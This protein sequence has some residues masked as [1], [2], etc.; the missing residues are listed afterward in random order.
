V[1]FR[2]ILAGVL[3]LFVI[4]CAATAAIAQGP[5]AP[6]PSVK[7]IA[8][9]WEGTVQVGRNAP[10]PVSIEIREDGSYTGQS[11]RGPIVGNMWMESGVVRSKSNN[12]PARWTLTVKDGKRTLH[13][14]AENG[15]GGGEFTEVK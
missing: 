8:G 13:S 5:A 14:M 4:S 11:P 10:V 9:K 3:L 1:R 7:D 2:I 6:I 15:Q 12:G